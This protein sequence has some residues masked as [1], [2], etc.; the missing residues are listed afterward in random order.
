MRTITLAALAVM[1]GSFTAIQAQGLAAATVAAGVVNDDVYPEHNVSFAGGVTGIPDLVFY[2]PSTYRAVRMDLYLPPPSFTRPRPFIVYTHGGGWSGGSK[3]TTGAFA[4]W[5]EVLAGFAA[6]G[7]VVASLDYRLL[8]DEIAPAAIQDTKA[9]IKFLRANAAKY[10]VDKAR[11]ST[12]GPSA[13]GQLAALAATSCGA[14]ALSPPPRPA[15]GR[16][17]AGGRGQ[18]PGRAA[19]VET[20]AAPPTGMDAE[21]DCVQAAV[22]WYGVYDFTTI[23]GGGAYLGCAAS[24]P[25]NIH[26]LEAESAIAYVNEKTPPILIVHGEKDTTVSVKQA[27]DFYAALK[28]KGVKAELMLLPEVGH[29][30]IGDTPDATRRASLKALE[31]TWQFID[32]TIGA[33]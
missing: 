19:T 33:R 25:C 18:S 26:T 29:S 32:E 12:W 20:A 15:R 3:R 2:S 11:G 17:P 7:Y 1:L 13:G 6:K 28:A 4:N 14:A 23:G 5:P 31:R 24:G 8:G 9:A 16:G 30:F 21:S 27:H 10:N 22:G